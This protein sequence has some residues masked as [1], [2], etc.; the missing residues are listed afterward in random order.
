MS[1]HCSP[2]MARLL[3][4]HKM[5]AEGLHEWLVQVFVLLQSWLH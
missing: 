4:S 3:L 1:W 5:V 2:V